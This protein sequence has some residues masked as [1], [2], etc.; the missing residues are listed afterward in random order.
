MGW[1]TTCTGTRLANP[2]RCYQRLP[3]PADLLHLLGAAGAAQGGWG[4]WR[5]REKTT[6]PL[7]GG[8]LDSW[9]MCGDDGSGVKFFLFCKIDH[10]MKRNEKW[11]MIGTPIIRRFV[12]HHH[13]PLVIPLVFAVAFQDRQKGPACYFCSVV[14]RSNE[15]S[16]NRSNGAVSSW[17]VKSNC[18]KR[19]SH[20]LSNDHNAFKWMITCIY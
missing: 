13:A 5:P 16:S 18:N 9:V 20:R 12:I 3:K 17:Y 8:F 1:Q 19:Q 11:L 15:T 7:I 6:R 4:G 14:A 2:I 10:V